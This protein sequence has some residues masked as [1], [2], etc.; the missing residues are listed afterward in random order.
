MHFHAV[1]VVIILL[2]F[3]MPAFAD[4]LKIPLIH[5]EASIHQASGQLADVGRISIDHIDIPGFSSSVSSGDP[6]L[7]CKLL[8]IALPPDADENSVELISDSYTTSLL[9]GRYDIAPVRPVIGADMETDW[10]TG[11]NIVAG[12]NTLVYN[13][14]AYYPCDNLR[15]QYIGHMRLWKIVV[16]EYWPYAYNP[17]TGKLR[18]IDSS[19]AIISYSYNQITA[20]LPADSAALD[21]SGLIENREEAAQWYN[22]IPTPSSTAS[23]VIITTSSIA[24]ASTELT[25]FANFQALRGFTVRVV[26]ES[27]WGGGVGDTAANNIRKWLLANYLSLGIQYVLL[28]GNPNPANGDVPMK[29]LWPRHNSSSYK[30]AP[31]DYYYAA[32]TGNWDRDGDGYAGEQPDDFGTGGIDRIADVYVG[33]IPY[34]G[35]INDLDNILQK[36]IDYE[37]IPQDDWSHNIILAMKPLDSYTPGYQLGE[38]INRDF[39][40]TRGLTTMRVYDSTYNLDPTPE[41]YPCSYDTVQQEWAKG[42]GL[43]FWMTHGS[44]TAASSVFTSSRCAS[45]DDSKPSIVCQ[46]SC[47]NGKPEDSGNLGY[48]LLRR[49][50]ISTL[51]ASRVA[52]Y[53]LEEDDFT[54]TDSIGGLSYQYAKYLLGHGES[55]GQALIDSRIAVTLSIWPNH[56]VFNLYGD[57]SLG[58]NQPIAGAFSGKIMTIDGFPITGATVQTSDGTHLTQS[59]TDGTYR[60]GKL[61]NGVHDIDIIAAG[62]Y[63]QHFHDIPASRGDISHM[64][65]RL[66]SA[67]PGSISGVVR[68]ISDSPIYGATVSIRGLSS[69][70]TSLY[71]GSYTINSVPPGTYTLVASKPPYAQKAIPG[72]RVGNGGA[73]TVDIN[74]NLYTGNLLSNGGFELGFGSGL[75]LYWDIYSSSGYPT[76]PL[77][78][79]DYYKYGSYSQKLHMSQPASE[80]HM[81]LRQTV[82]VAPGRSYK[83]LGWE[84]NYFD[85][86][87]SASS[88]NI[89]CRI[90]YDPSGG[91]SISASSVVWNDFLST[92]GF[93]TSAAADI[94]SRA[95]TLTIFL[96]AWRKLPGGGDN[97]YAWFDGISLSGPIDAPSVP[98][99]EVPST[100]QTSGDSISATWICSDTNV[101]GY[102]CAVS[103]TAGNDGIVP[104]GDWLNVGLNKS[105]TR[106]GLGLRDGD[107][108]RVLVR[109]TNAMG[110]TG[111]IGASDLVRIIGNTAGA[112]LAQRIPDGSWVRVSGMRITRMGYEPECFIEDIDRIYGVKVMG[113][114]NSIPYIASGTQVDVVGRYVLSDGMRVLIDAEILPST[115]DTPVKPVAML[116]KCVGLGINAGLLVSIWGRVTGLSETGMIVTD[117]S[118]PDGLQVDC[119]GVSSIP[120]VG[121]YV[122]IT[123][124]STHDGLRVY[125]VEDIIKIL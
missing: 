93:W 99:V 21:M 81:G 13:T 100:I 102:E 19:N 71:D 119:H 62:Y 55:C 32:L 64:D 35:N 92:H 79:I 8:Y 12:R 89:L 84:R 68:D 72:C 57:P 73:V 3:R 114:W 111:E 38:E 123:G 83:L 42:A 9:S 27:E 78:G 75:S 44:S 30:D 18:Y 31:S 116:N 85:G 77:M 88:D 108:V 51:S 37:S 43:V 76:E 65:F 124:I 49:G 60:L 118:L 41:C 125:D 22:T 104:G 109:A 67:M 61:D 91:T 122:R 87:E 106:L 86:Q 50:A 97:C 94:V 46:A 59:Q 117:G 82:S 56:L 110:V 115:I 40:P 54:N 69:S 58:Y 39:G 36:I 5:S 16:L 96:D 66:V 34:Y 45:L 4:T 1:M 63:S 11:K 26:T 47:E 24:S 105:V 20:A 28:I 74:L 112:R 6:A 23:Y 107:A 2:S 53:Y 120:A 52:W 48:S 113:T 103:R 14:D 95:D 25:D 80:G 10:G 90:G 98:V 7:P 101:A 17:S 33:R 70:T 29:L 121:S 15:I